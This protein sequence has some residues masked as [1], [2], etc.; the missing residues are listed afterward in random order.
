MNILLAGGLPFEYEG[1]PLSADF[2]NMVSADLILR[3]PEIPGVVRMRLA[4]TQLYEEVPPDTQKAMDGFRWFLSR[5]QGGKGDAGAA[6]PSGRSFCFQQDA[7]L[8][9]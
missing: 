5:G 9:G 1:I 2:R 7:N 3:D 8:M 6:G 4:L